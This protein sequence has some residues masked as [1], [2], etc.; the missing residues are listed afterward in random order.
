[1]NWRPARDRQA[2]RVARLV[3]FGLLTIASSGVAVLYLLPLAARGFVRAIELLLA[4]CVWLAMSLSVGMSVWSVLGVIG[5]SVAGLVATRQASALLAL[6]VVVGALAAYGL[7][8][9][10]SSEEESS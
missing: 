1:M 6:L 9:L 7:Q 4:A 2:T 3:G 8:R 10:L 5:R